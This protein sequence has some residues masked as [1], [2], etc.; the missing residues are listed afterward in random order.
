MIGT[1]AS[2]RE[3][4]LLV[5]PNVQHLRAVRLVAADTAGRA[6]FD[7]EQTDD[8]RI[9]VDELC[10]SVMRFASGPI[11]LVFAADDDRVTIE[12]SAPCD[13]PG[14]TPPLLDPLSEAILNSVS[15][16]FE[17]ID[18]PPDVRFMLVMERQLACR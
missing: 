18:S 7:I 13:P 8:L 1:T 17:I 12:G 4:R 5:P 16:F 2:A 6:G 9:A 14:P 3:L 11:T 15:Q 10:H